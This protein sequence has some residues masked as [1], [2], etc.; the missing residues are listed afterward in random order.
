[1]YPVI[2]YIPA[3]AT[4]TVVHTTNGANHRII[5]SH[6]NDN[7]I[8]TKQELEGLKVSKSNNFSITMSTYMRMIFQV[9][10]IS[11]HIWL[12]ILR[13]FRDPL[14]ASV[15]V[16]EAESP[17]GAIWSRMLGIHL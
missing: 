9:S 12:A 6:K 4:K 13:A 16:E 8:A 15:V 3:K 2:Q 11:P 1:M 17:D 14:A 5:I 7:T 10:R